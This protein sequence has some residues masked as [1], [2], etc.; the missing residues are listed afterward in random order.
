MWP[1]SHLQR[2]TCLE[3]PKIKT[4]H[5]K[6]SSPCLGY[7]PFQSITDRLF[8]VWTIKE[9]WK[10][11]KE[12]IK[13]VIP[14]NSIFCFLSMYILAT[15]KPCQTAGK[16]I[17]KIHYKIIRVQISIVKTLN[18]GNIWMWLITALQQKRTFTLP[19]TKNGIFSKSHLFA[20]N[21]LNIYDWMR[22]SAFS[23]NSCIT[24]LSAGQNKQTCYVLSY[25][26]DISLQHSIGSSLQG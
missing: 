7:Q 15:Y 14:L 5:T 24:S 19:K 22:L 10:A 26:W 3:I 4:A 8:S 1:P 11:D 6:G 13:N 18:S 20:C 16:R 12:N 21:N 23:Q 25:L 9:C 17:T 2:P